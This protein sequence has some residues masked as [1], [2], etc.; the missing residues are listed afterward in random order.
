MRVPILDAFMARKRWQN[1]RPELTTFEDIEQARRDAPYWAALVKEMP[2]FD[3]EFHTGH[4]YRLAWIADASFWHALVKRFSN[5]D[6]G[7]NRYSFWQPLS[8]AAMESGN[9]IALDALAQQYAVEELWDSTRSDFKA[10]IHP[11]TLT[12][13]KEHDTRLDEELAQHTYDIIRKVKFFRDTMYDALHA[14]SGA[15]SLIHWSHEW[16]KLPDTWRDNEESTWQLLSHL[17]AQLNLLKHH[18][19]SPGVTKFINFNAD[20]DDNAVDIKLNLDSK[21]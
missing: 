5:Y 20:I 9:T 19:D 8:Y 14:T 2:E 13:F 11:R 16:C 21:K 6:H 3:E 1:G 15:E 4:A 18:P 17:S 12:W 7:F 10:T